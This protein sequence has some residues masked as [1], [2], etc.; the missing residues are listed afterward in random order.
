MK[1][2]IKTVAQYYGKN[3]LECSLEEAIENEQEEA[4]EY[5]NRSMYVNPCKLRAGALERQE[6]Y[7]SAIDFQNYC[8]L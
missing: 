3:E 2:L 8:P 4:E 5:A 1:K 6:K 7:V